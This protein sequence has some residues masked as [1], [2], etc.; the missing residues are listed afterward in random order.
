M[1][2]GRNRCNHP[3][4]GLAQGVDLAAL[5]VRSEV[6]GEDLPIVLQRGVAGK[7]EHVAGAAH[8]IGRVLLAQPALGGDEVGNLLAARPQRLGYLV[9]DPVA[10]VASQ[11]RAERLSDPDRP[12]YLG[13]GSLG[14]RAHERAGVRIEHFA[15]A[16]GRDARAADTQALAPQPAVAADAG[17]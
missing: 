16:L 11:A 3:Q 5:A 17:G 1:V 14:Y 4:Q 10:L 12:A 8:F 6:A 13:H 7:D 2:E 9:A 15:A